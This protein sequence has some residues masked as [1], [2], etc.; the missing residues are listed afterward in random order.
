MHGKMNQILAVG[1][2]LLLLAT[3]GRSEAG[4]REALA[5]FETGATKPTPCAA[6]RVIGSRKEV[7]RFQ[8]LPS[9]WRQYSRSRDYYNPEVAWN[10]A[11][12]ILIDREKWFRTATGREWDAI[13]LYLM[14]NAPGEYQRAKWNRSRVSRVVMQ[15]AKRFANIFEVHDERLYVRNTVN[16]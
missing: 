2:A 4:V 14:W 9:V 5:H 1:I 6:D 7:S 11:A 10:V 13:D 12:K 3:A 15:R 16:D 8:I